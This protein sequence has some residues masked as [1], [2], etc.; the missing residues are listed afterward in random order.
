[1]HVMLSALGI[2]L[3][4]HFIWPWFVHGAGKFDRE[5]G[6]EWAGHHFY[7][8][9]IICITGMF[10]VLKY[11]DSGSLGFITIVTTD[12][13]TTSIVTTV[14]I[15]FGYGQLVAASFSPQFEDGTEQSDSMRTRLY[16]FFGFSQLDPANWKYKPNKI[17]M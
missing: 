15:M 14:A 9:A 10:T 8:L 12:Q 3:T 16:R 5:I 4:L 1:M 6:G 13:G 2:F 7:L 17:L 11:G